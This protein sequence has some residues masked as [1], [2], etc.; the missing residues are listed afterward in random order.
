MRL[1]IWLAAITLLLSF[2]SGYA[3][4]PDKS[5]EQQIHTIYE[6]IHNAFKQ[7]DV[8]HLGEAYYTHDALLFPPTGG[9]MEGPEE[10]T[11]MFEGMLAGGAILV[12]TP[13]EIEVYGDHAYERGVGAIHNPQ[14]DVLRKDNYIV[15]WKKVDGQWKMYR[16]LVQGL[17]A[18]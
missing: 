12:A 7:G 8:S 11:A 5:A 1:S 17:P 14:G 16:D 3:M 15:I 13:L 18:E 4:S 9:V 10:I 2:G 6:E